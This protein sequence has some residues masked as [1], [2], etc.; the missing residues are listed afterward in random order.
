MKF[1]PIPIK[2]ELTR[3]VTGQIAAD[4]NPLILSEDMV[5]VDLPN[6]VLIYAGWYDRDNSPAKYRI[7]VDYEL[8]RLIPYLETDDPYE[9]A[10]EVAT[11]AAQYQHYPLHASEYP[12][13]ASDS[14]STETRQRPFALVG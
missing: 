9:A 2:R 13:Q 8:H 5:E 7:Y 6:G 4:D 11:L 14:E 1:I 10:W 3:F 12:L